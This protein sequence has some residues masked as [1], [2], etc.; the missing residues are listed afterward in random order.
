MAKLWANLASVLGKV[1]PTIPFMARRSCSST[2]QIIMKAE[3]GKYAITLNRPDVLNALTLQMINELFLLLKRINEDR[4]TK[5][6]IL[7]GAGQRAFC[8]GGDLKAL[9][10]ASRKEAK[11]TEVL[12]RDEYRLNHLIGTLRVPFVALIDGIVMGGGVGLSVHSLFRVATRRTTFAM[13]E[14]AIGFFPDVGGSYF[15]PRLAGRLGTFLGLTGTR[16]TGRDV[17]DAGIATHFVNAEEMGQLE[18]DLMKNEEVNDATSIRNVLERYHAKGC[19]QPHD[20]VL[21]PHLKRIDVAFSADR[22][23]EVLRRLRDDRSNW[24][25]DCIAQLER[26]SPTSLKVTLKEMKL[27]SALSFEECFKMEYRLSQRIVRR[28]DFYEGVRSVL[29]DKDGNPSWSPRTLAQVNDESLNDYFS[30]LPP[31]K[32]LQFD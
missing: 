14:T 23:E 1:A 27:G 20:F 24:A 4:T 29:I 7:K 26:M 28:H 3:G 13:P 25:T 6:V 31:E 16:L 8:A 30:P 5:L 2:R 15:L 11:L 10:E 9:A 21:S 19:N 32:E 22:M 12:F 18:E 17:Y